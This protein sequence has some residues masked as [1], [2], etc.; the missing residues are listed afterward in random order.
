[1]SQP[2]VAGSEPSHAGGFGVGRFVGEVVGGELG[3]FVGTGVGGFVGEGVG[4]SV[5]LFV[6]YGDHKKRR[7]DFFESVNEST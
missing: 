4:W 2:Q 7:N 1:M 6:G 5:G 3:T